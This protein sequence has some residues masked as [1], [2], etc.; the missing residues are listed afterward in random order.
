MLEINYPEPNF[1]IK[2]ENGREFLFDPI[3]KKWL[4]LTEEEWVRQNFI[5]Y[6][7]EIK[8]YPSALIALEKI[9]SLGELKKRFDILVY[10]RNHRPWMMVECKEMNV[11]LSDAVLQ[12]VLRYN[13][14]VPVRFIVITNG[15]QTL[16]WEKTDAQLESISELPP[17]K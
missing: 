7:V 5:Q 15:K 9:I 13:I 17:L 2:K 3:R 4:L 10:D 16:G 14:A 6:L 12:Q 1:R 11:A 8:N